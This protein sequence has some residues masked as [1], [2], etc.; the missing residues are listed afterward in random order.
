MS[1]Y[2]ASGAWRQIG[3]FGR[4]FPYAEAMRPL[5]IVAL[6]VVEIPLKS[7]YSTSPQEKMQRADW[8]NRIGS[9]RRN[10]IQIEFN[11][12]RVHLAPQKIH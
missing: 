3:A 5:L 11:A 9:G 10:W 7:I 1:V 12:V 4:G 8:S 2:G 6:L